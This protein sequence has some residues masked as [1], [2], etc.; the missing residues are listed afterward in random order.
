MIEVKIGDVLRP[1][2]FG[3]RRLGQLP[4]VS[5]GPGDLGRRGEDLVDDGVGQGA[6][7][8]GLGER[9]GG[10]GGGSE[11]DDG[12]L[13]VGE[14]ERGEEGVELGKEVWGGGGVGHEEEG[15]GREGGD[16]VVGGEGD[17]DV[18][19]E[20]GAE[21]ECSLASGEVGEDDRGGG[22]GGGGGGGAGGGRGGGGGVGAEALEEAAFEEEGE[23]Q[24][25]CKSLVSM[26]L[27]ELHFGGKRDI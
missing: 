13:P 15:G 10:A 9:R 25:M 20:L 19:A 6:H 16:E 11:G 24:G 12:V 4:G 22:G 1:P 21:L 23:L 8:G 14:D 2:V 5:E 18:V 17:G 27:L 26:R 7:D 3:Y